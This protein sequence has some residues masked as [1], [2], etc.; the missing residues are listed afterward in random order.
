VSRFWDVWRLI[1]MAVSAALLGASQL[2][3][4]P[5]PTWVYP[6]VAAIALLSLLA[7]LVIDRRQRG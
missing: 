7:A 5:L 3:P 4:N 6:V 2:Q 1:G